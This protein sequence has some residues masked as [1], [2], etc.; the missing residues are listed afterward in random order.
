MKKNLI[1]SK[2]PEDC[3]NCS[4]VTNEL[5]Q[6]KNGFDFMLI[7]ERLFFAIC[8]DVKNSWLDDKLTLAGLWLF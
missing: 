3:N 4:R 8:G 1:M 2:C 6:F 7:Y 5:N